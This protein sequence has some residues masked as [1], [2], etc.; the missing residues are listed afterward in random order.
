LTI[1]LPASLRRIKPQKHRTQLSPR[2]S[3]ELVSAAGLAA[4]GRAAI[5]LDTNV[6]IR[7]AA[8]TLVDR[9]LL[10]HCSVC[11]L[12]WWIELVKQSPGVVPTPG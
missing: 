10:F 3:T 11:V 9:G 8:A 1:D 6:Y 5:V 4:D 7:S 12:D 2:P